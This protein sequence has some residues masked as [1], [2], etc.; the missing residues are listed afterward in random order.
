VN[1]VGFIIRIQQ[2]KFVKLKKFVRDS[3]VKRI[4]ITQ[5]YEDLVYLT[6]NEPSPTEAGTETCAQC[7]SAEK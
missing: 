5:S 1:F 6:G 2:G 4:D 3:V 7:V